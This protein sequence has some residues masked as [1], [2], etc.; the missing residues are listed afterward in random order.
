MLHINISITTE[1]SPANHVIKSLI[2]ESKWH[3]GGRHEHKQ[4][5][6]CFHPPQPRC[7]CLSLTD[8]SSLC[9]CQAWFWFLCPK[10][11]SNCF[12]AVKHIPVSNTPP[13]V[14]SKRGDA[15]FLTSPHWDVY[16]LRSCWAAVCEQSAFDANDSTRPSKLAAE[17]IWCMQQLC[18]K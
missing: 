2:N 6:F 1:T 7:G 15:V 10:C 18:K 3:R 4:T 11:H 13:P 12:C 16:C 17:M 8:F 9:L 5:P 14:T